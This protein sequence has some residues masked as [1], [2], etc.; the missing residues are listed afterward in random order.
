AG[1]V[2]WTTS[3]QLLGMALDYGVAGK[4]PVPGPNLW[5]GSVDASVGT[6]TSSDVD[7]VITISG[8]DA[9][10]RGRR[11]VLVSGLIIGQSYEV[12]F[13]V[14]AFSGGAL[15]FDVGA[16]TNATGSFTDSANTTSTRSFRGF[17]VATATSRYFTFFTGA[18]GATATIENVH[19]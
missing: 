16:S 3:G 12:N 9:S 11:S 13:N 17:Y 14:T 2:P 8:D 18:S 19:V 4:K 1:T 10:N 15:G 5:V 6:G 7:G